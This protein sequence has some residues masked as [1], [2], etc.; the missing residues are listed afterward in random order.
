MV[1]V[2]GGWWW[3]SACFPSSLKT[4][5]ATG[6]EQLFI[7]NMICC[8]ILKCI[9]PKYIFPNGILPN[10]RIFYWRVYLVN[11]CVCPHIR[12]PWKWQNITG[13][14]A[15]VRNLKLFGSKVNQQFFNNQ[16][17]KK[18]RTGKHSFDT[19]HCH[20]CHRSH[21]IHWNNFM[22]S[23]EKKQ[24]K[25]LKW[26]KPIITFCTF[27]IGNSLTGQHLAMCKFWDSLRP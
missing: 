17:S 6:K 16:D 19:N 4:R 3:S 27:W 10:L 25:W 15:V 26:W 22:K 24:W 23:C 13:A 1:C 7:I 2:Q 11:N 12:P 14:T 9:S 21:L 18:S 20:H 5:G 8:A